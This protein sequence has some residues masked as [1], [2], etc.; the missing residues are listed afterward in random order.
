MGYASLCFDRKHTIDQVYA[1]LLNGQINPTIFKKWRILHSAFDD[2]QHLCHNACQ[3]NNTMIRN[4]WFIPLFLIM[5]LLTGCRSQSS[6]SQPIP[7]GNTPQIL[8]D[9]DIEQEAAVD[10][11]F[12][13][14]VKI[15]AYYYPWYSADRHWNSGYLGT[16]VLGEYDSANPVVIAQ[17]ISW[18]VKYNIDFFV[19]SWWGIGSFE[20]NVLR[21]PFLD[22][23]VESDLNFAILYESAGLLNLNNGKIN[24]ND[25]ATRQR[26][27]SDF[28]YLA[29]KVMQHPNYLTIHD[30][31]VIF[32]YLTRTFTGDVEAALSEAKVTAV[33]TG[34][35]EPFIIGDEVYWQ[36]P[37]EERIKLYEGVTAYNMHTSVPDIAD[38]FATDVD[39]Q[40]R[41]WAE[42]TAKT[43]T[44]FIPNILPGF[45]D[46]AVRPEAKHPVIPRSEDLFMEQYKTAMD[47]AANDI[48]IIMVTSWNEWHENTSIEPS[49]EEGTAYLEILSNAQ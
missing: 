35:K 19:L 25:A 48:G 11:E 33:N 24:I 4:R 47:L 32:L 49:K 22:T 43:S 37:D 40:Y 20:D 31:P 17:H 30:R 27:V 21:G 18:A 29:K 8:P 34:S 12:Q 2:S 23:V 16:P 9:T 44:A 39:R 14:S 26:M 42:N 36:Y 46:T 5:G 6:A 3:D 41:L 7:P 10:M 45:D 1:F 13:Q 15:G 38:G 28:S